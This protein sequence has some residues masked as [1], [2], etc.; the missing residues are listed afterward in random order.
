[1][2]Q[3]NSKHGEKSYHLTTTK[4]PNGH[5]SYARIKW[6][7]C[8]HHYSMEWGSNRVM[9]VEIFDIDGNQL[10]RWG[11]V[12]DLVVGTC[13]KNGAT[14]SQA[15]AHIKSMPEYHLDD[16]YPLWTPSGW[17][18]DPSISGTDD[19]GYPTRKQKGSE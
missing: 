4:T 5:M 7:D 16:D 9:V 10:N 1:M 11:D 8:V 6:D 18:L 12:M 3:G 2:V 14:K 13:P 17:T 15:I 19:E